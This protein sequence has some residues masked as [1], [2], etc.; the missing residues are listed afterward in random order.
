[1]NPE[2]D[3]AKYIRTLILESDLPR[4]T[5]QELEMVAY[6]YTNLARIGGLLNQIAHVLNIEKL[7]YYDGEQDFVTVPP[8]LEQVVTDAKKELVQLKNQLIQM[9]KRKVE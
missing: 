8:R 4:F 9:S 2:R 7:R 1:M 6:Y 5:P 3:T